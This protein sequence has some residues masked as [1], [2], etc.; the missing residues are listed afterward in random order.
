MTLAT[1]CIHMSVFF[2][3]RALTNHWYPFRHVLM[4]W[5]ARH[6][7]KSEILTL[8]DLGRKKDPWSLPSSQAHGVSE[9][10][11]LRD[12][13]SKI[14]LE[15]ATEEN[16]QHLPLASTCMCIHVYTC[17]CMSIHIHIHEGHIHVKPFYVI[18]FSKLSIIICHPSI[19]LP[20]IYL[21]CNTLSK[22]GQS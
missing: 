13:I 20:I 2:P 22:K 18:L 21:L 14:K 9:L 19:Q 3:F 12:S 5:K 4:T 10:S 15:R 17:L 8:E 7:S 1:A 16:T 6:G 11:L